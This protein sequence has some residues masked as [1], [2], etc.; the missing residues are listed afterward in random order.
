M[1]ANDNQM[2]ANI[3]SHNVNGG[4]LMYSERTSFHD[5]QF[6]YNRSLAS[7][8]GIM[9]KDVD[10]IDITGNRIHHNRIGLAL[11]GA[12]FSPG[13]YQTSQPRRV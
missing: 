1:Y 10:D 13:S 6:A 12:P 2:I 4:V 3:F 7:G 9:F 8:Y 5:N 11:E